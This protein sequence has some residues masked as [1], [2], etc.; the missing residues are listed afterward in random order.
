MSLRTNLVVGAVF[1]ALLA[2]VYFYEIKGGE[3]RAAEASTA[4]ELLSFRES[5]AARLTL[6]R[7]DTLIVLEKL[8]GEWRLTQPVTD[9]ADQ[10]AVERYL[11][12]LRES[13]REGVVA[14]SAEV[15]ASGAV[16]GRYG[17]DTPRLEV[18]LELDEGALDTVV[19]G[20]DSPMER[21]SYA[22]Q[23]G[24]NQEIFKVRAWRFDNV[25]K[26]VFDL[27]D[28]RVLPFT[29]DDV[30][31]V[32]LEGVGG[33]IMLERGQGNSWRLTE[34]VSGRA[35]GD[36][37]G[38]LLS[39]LQDGKAAAFAAEDPGPDQL[40]DYGVAP[41]QTLEVSL[42]VGA[43]RAEKRLRIGAPTASGHYYARDMSA[44]QVMEIDTAL[45][46][47]LNKTLDE[48]RDHTVVRF[49]RS[50]V[51]RVELHRPG[52]DLLA[53]QMDT[54]R[55]WSVAEPQSLPARAWK[56]TA[57][58]SDLEA[59]AARDFAAPDGEGVRGAALL[60]RC[61]LSGASG[62]LVDVSFTSDVGG[63]LYATC[64]GDPAV[65]ILDPADFTSLDLRLDDLAEMP[66]PEPASAD[67]VTAQP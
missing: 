44:P 6:D 19:F 26:G 64:A 53:V 51:A 22:Q 42:L 10:D 12:N 31:S 43:E 58:L 57:L 24:A 47:D 3:E 8:D 39:R 30:Q 23:R 48:L 33:R 60:L 11:G 25:D 34:P 54:A 7:G 62:T 21:F 40:A 14:D 41:V 50:Q 65:Y 38:S 46:R 49:T 15:A 1:A 59:L 5:A 27:R 29:S 66:E 61:V 16:A 55:V 17:L 36:A 67:S 18:L 9:T 52:E 37:V 28:K 56:M 20:D 2:F 63:A 35:D 32:V 45:V 4:K 13:E